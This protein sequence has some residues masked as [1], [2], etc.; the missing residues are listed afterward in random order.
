MASRIESHS[1]FYA[2]HLTLALAVGYM[3]ITNMAGLYIASDLGGS[4]E[5]SVY[6]M[7]F[8]GLGNLFSIPITASLADRFGPLRL[9][10]F[11]LLLYTVFSHLCA[12]AS[13]FFILNLYRVGLGFSAGF[14]YVLCRELMVAFAPEERFKTYAFIT[15]LIFAVMPVVGVSIGAW[16]AYETHWRWIFYINEPIALVLALYFWRKIKQLDPE[17]KP[18]ILDK[19]GYFFFCL[20][21]TSLLTAATLS[22]QLDWYRSWT[23]VGLVAVGLPSL[24][25]FFLWSRLHPTPLFE[26]PLLKSPLLSFSLV[27]LAILFSSYFGMIILISLWLNI[28]A[29]YTPLWIAVLVGIMGVAAVAAFLA[30]K[31][32]LRRFD[33]RVTL[34]LAI[35]TLA[36][37]CYYSTYFDVDV[38]FFHL[39]VARSLAGFGL[40]LFLFPIF[41]LSLGSYGPEKGTS[42]YVFFQVTRVLSSALGAGLYVILWQRRQVFFHERLGENIT[43]TSQL[44]AQYFDQATRIF[45]LTQ[46]QAIEQLSVFQQQHATS[47]ALNDVFGFMGYVLIGLFAVLFGTWKYTRPSVDPR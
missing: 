39:A 13:T 6:P 33:P 35:L 5:I 44:T 45:Y 26:L 24:I 41:D 28:Y 20:S 1:F 12:M 40:M 34:G 27:S 46:E 43:A 37:S 21:I 31:T 10:V 29:N 7:V 18:L 17:P 30:S 36:S 42:I 9:L 11:A 3:T 25:F 15:V 2:L 14:F 38:D 8:F 23:L 22:Q 16:L 4:A 19:V 32:F 47:L